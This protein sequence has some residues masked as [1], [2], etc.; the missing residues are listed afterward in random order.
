MCF[1]RGLVG[2][3]VMNL[4]LGVAKACQRVRQDDTAGS[5]DAP[6]PGGGRAVCAIDADRWM[7]WMDSAKT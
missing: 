3:F 7:A 6:P 5:E 2:G 1:F 4:L